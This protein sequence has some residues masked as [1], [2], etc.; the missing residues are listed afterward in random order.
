VINGS[1]FMKIQGAAKLT[2]T[3]YAL[4]VQVFQNPNPKET[5]L[6]FL[7]DNGDILSAHEY[8][9]NANAIWSSNIWKL[10]NDKLFFRFDHVQSQPT[11][12]TF[13]LV[14]TTGTVLQYLPIDTTLITFVT[15]IKAIDSANY[16]EKT[17]S[18]NLLQR[19]NIAQP[20][21]ACETVMTGAIHSAAVATSNPVTTVS[22]FYFP[23]GIP[24]SPAVVIKQINAQPYC[25]AS[26]LPEYR[27]DPFSLFPNPNNGAFEIEGPYGEIEILDLLGNRVYAGMKQAGKERFD[28]KDKPGGLYFLKFHMADGV[29]VKKIL[30]RR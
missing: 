10:D 20:P 17:N 27:A 22:Q 30:I 23:T 26:S 6:L 13:C 3:L 29:V 12:E 14:D 19:K 28:L 18:G 1:D 24:Y 21:S 7:D 8:E 11:L 16:Y 5:V 15:D 9:S 4:A 2:N 25:S